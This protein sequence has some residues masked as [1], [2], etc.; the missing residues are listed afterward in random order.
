MAASTNT[1]AALEERVDAEPADDEHRP[2]SSTEDASPVEE[3]S[4]GDDQVTAATESGPTT[5]RRRWRLSTLTAGAI[6]VSVAIAAVTAL[7]A[8]LGWQTLQAHDTQQH[9]DVVLQ[10]G[11]QAAINL[12]SIDYTTVDTD[13]QRV[14]DGSVGT[15]HDEFQTNASAFANVVR[16]AQTKTH[17]SVTE[18]GVESIDGDTAQLLVTASV[19]TSSAGAPEQQPRIWRMRIT[20]AQTPGGAKVS[21]VGFVP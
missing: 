3:T 10:V 8:S 18:A 16:Q 11:R 17:G 21:N 5:R 1:T 7:A 2:V 9:R 13:I 15:F 20:V 14:L 19:Q 12:T 6:A 4:A